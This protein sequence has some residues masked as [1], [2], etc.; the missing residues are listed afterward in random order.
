MCGWIHVCICRCAYTSDLHVCGWMDGW[1]GETR[2]VK[3]WQQH[4]PE[5]ERT[6]TRCASIEGTG[7]GGREGRQGVRKTSKRERKRERHRDVRTH[8][9]ALLSITAV[10]TDDVSSAD[11]SLSVVI[12][13]EHTRVHRYMDAVIDPSHHTLLLSLALPSSLFM[14]HHLHKAKF[15]ICKCVCSHTAF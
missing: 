9:L 2:C 5:G 13:A 15:F 11:R 4:K 10:D 3:V 14:V 1:M 6:S 8:A 12:P 7:G